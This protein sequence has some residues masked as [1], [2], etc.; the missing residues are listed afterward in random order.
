MKKHLTL[1]RIIGA[2][3]IVASV[4]SFFLQNWAIST[5]TIM[6][7]ISGIV[8]LFLRAPYAKKL[9]TLFTRTFT[10][11]PGLALATLYEFLFWVVFA[12]VTMVYGLY[13]RRTMTKLGLVQLET[14]ALLQPDILA[15][16]LTL[17]Q[18]FFAQIVGGFIIVVIAVII[19]YALFSGLVW[20]T[21]IGKTLSKKAFKK[22]LLFSTVWIGSTV[23]LAILL[24]LAFR[25][26]Y[27]RILAPAMFLVFVHL[28]LIANALLAKNLSVRKTISGTFSKGLQIH[29]IVIPYL[30]VYALYLVAYGV[31]SLTTPFPT[32]L[33]IAS[34][35]T[36]LFFLVWLKLYIS[37][38]LTLTK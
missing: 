30:Y 8:L 17:I 24:A 27:L 13:A 16:N 23:I 3:F 15:N 20:R 5:T 14:D 7:A 36:T 21:L 29:R 18:S 32:V 33:G 6:A 28:T 34:G 1:N 26:E 22:Y 38:V 35:I 19:T 37:Q 12:I 25:P 4:L 2:L 11:R 10:R 31:V 9:N